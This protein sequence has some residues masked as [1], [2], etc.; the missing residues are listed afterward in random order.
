MPERPETQEQ[1]IKARKSQLFEA[2]K[3]SNPNLKV[4]RK[5]FPV[6]VRETP[7]SPLSAGVKALLWGLTVVVLG[8]LAFAIASP[9]KAKP[10]PK[11]APAAKSVRK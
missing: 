10:K 11:P 3:K 4:P 8:L 6:L 7:A 2:E 9:G 5:P 1:S